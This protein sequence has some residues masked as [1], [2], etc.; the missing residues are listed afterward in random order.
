MSS[1][2]PGIVQM[3]QLFA[4]ALILVGC[5]LFYLGFQIRVFNASIRTF[6]ESIKTFK[7]TV[8]LM[9]AAAQHPLT[10]AASAA[11]KTISW[12]RS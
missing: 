6:N 10:T 8:D 3:E 9:R 7:D 2:F 5:G 1:I 4:F 11:S 12:L